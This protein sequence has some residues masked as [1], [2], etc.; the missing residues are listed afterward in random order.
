VK[1]HVPLGCDIP[2]VVAAHVTVSHISW[3]VGM[4]GIDHHRRWVAPW[5]RQWSMGDRIKR[6]DA[7]QTKCLLL[8]PVASVGKRELKRSRRE[9]RGRDNLA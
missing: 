9:L 2:S 3:R 4:L 5:G 1:A 8:W 6:L 7:W